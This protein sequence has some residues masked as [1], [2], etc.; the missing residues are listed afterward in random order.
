MTKEVQ[1]ELPLTLGKQSS[2]NHTQRH[3]SFDLGRDVF[4]RQEISERVKPIL[5]LKMRTANQSP[6]FQVPKMVLGDGR[7]E[8]ANVPWSVWP[9]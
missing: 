3:A 5:S 9:R 2:E 1:L 7:V 6:F 8:A 4:D